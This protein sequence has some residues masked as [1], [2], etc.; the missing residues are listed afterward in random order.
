MLIPGKS[1]SRVVS[2]NSRVSIET[3]NSAQVHTFY[4]RDRS[5]ITGVGA[6][7]G[8]RSPA[9]PR[10]R[11]RPMWG[12]HRSIDI[13]GGG[14]PETSQNGRGRGR[15]GK[16]NG[17]SAPGRRAGESPPASVGCRWTTGRRRRRMGARNCVQW[18]GL[19]RT[20]QNA[21]LQHDGG[22]RS[23]IGPW[24]AVGC[25]RTISQHLSGLSC[26]PCGRFSLLL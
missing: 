12:P 1:H 10:H 26:S 18:L 9:G 11:S 3:L 15:P 4:Q 24:T 17:R 2:R 8:G 7:G 23:P 13:S 25:G 21:D 22:M 19:R 20:C 14:V 16:R 6:R 5:W